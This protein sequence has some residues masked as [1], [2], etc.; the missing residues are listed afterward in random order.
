MSAHTNNKFGWR[1]TYEYVF[2]TGDIKTVVIGTYR[3][4]WIAKLV[5]LWNFPVGLD[6]VYIKERLL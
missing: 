3:W 6:A 5:A 4:K 2:Y 1:V